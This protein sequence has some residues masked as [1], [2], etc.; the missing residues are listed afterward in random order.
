MEDIDKIEEKFLNKTKLVGNN[1]NTIESKIETIIDLMFTG[2]YDKEMFDF[3]D[4]SGTILLHGIPGVGK[5]S[6]AKNIMSYAIDKYGVES[7]IIEPSDIIV[8]GLGESVKNLSDKLKNFEKLGE[9]ILFI[10]EIDK[11]CVN[12]NDKDELSEMKRLLIELMTF[13][14]RLSLCTKKILIGCTN[15]FEYMD[16]AIKRRFSICEKIM[17]PSSEEKKIFFSL[18]YEKTGSSLKYEINDEFISHFKTMDSI[19]S[20]FRNKILTNKLNTIENEINSNPN[21]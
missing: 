2:N 11:F 6:I 15:V 3:F 13:I 18:C 19:K 9:G 1:C 12:R 10:D 7:Y 8:S 21:K 5:T 14:D 16:P 17:E 20:Y 4:I